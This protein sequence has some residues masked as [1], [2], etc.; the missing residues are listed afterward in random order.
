MAKFLVTHFPFIQDHAFQQTRTTII[1]KKYVLLMRME[2]GRMINRCVGLL[3]FLSHL[4]GLSCKFLKSMDESLKRAFKAIVK[5]EDILQSSKSLTFSQR[6][7]ERI[8]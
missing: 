5:S 7:S 4:L 3:P 1:N 2:E 6:Q 8:V